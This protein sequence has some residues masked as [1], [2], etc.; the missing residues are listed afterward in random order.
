MLSYP[1]AGSELHV[2][3]G[4]YPLR[5]DRLYAALWRRKLAA[6]KSTRGKLALRIQ[7]ETPTRVPRLRKYLTLDG[8]QNVELKT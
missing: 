8:G 7:A 5:S 2:Q 6:T 4:S 1:P 3:I